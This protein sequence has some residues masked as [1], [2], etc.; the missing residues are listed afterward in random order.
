MKIQN[1]ILTKPITCLGTETIAK[2]TKKLKDN[3]LRHL[4]V[5]DKNKKLL[6]VFAGID[7]VY[8][9]IAEGK[10]YKKMKVS[11]IM[12]ANIVSFEPDDSLTKAL[13][14]M[15]TSNIFTTPIVRKG[16]L[17]AVLSYKEAMQYAVNERR[18]I[19]KK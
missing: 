4:Y 11:E 8:K 18:K 7:V 19:L 13:G 2:A 1:C 14:F 9:V 17:V 15:S 3:Q 16:K 10:D 12:N 6:G 5:V